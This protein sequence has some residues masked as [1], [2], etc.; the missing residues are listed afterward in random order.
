M[1]NYLA[2]GNIGIFF[3]HEAFIN[4]LWSMYSRPKLL[5][6]NALR[7]DFKRLPRTCFYT[8]H[9]VRWSGSQ[10]DIADFTLLI[11]S[12]YK[13]PRQIFDRSQIYRRPH[14]KVRRHPSLNNLG[15]KQRQLPLSLCYLSS[16]NTFSST[17]TR[18]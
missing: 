17:T 7:L 6:V 16:I 10:M 14:P 9:A 5:R 11:I 13:T 8:I 12:L 4:W 2:I 3:V 1:C 15:Y 18:A